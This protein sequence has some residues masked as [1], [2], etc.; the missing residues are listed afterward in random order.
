MGH[1]D[2]CFDVIIAPW[3]GTLAGKVGRNP[4]D[5]TTEEIP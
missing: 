5:M 4:I 1:D 3:G 2:S